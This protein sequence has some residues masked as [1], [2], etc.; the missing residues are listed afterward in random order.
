MAATADSESELE[1]VENL[2]AASEGESDVDVVSYDCMTC[3]KSIKSLEECYPE[4]QRKGGLI[5]HCLKCFSSEVPLGCSPQK[6]DE[7]VTSIEEKYETDKRL[8]LVC[9]LFVRLLNN[10][11]NN[12]GSCLITQDQK[13]RGN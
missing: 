6:A 4:D 10:N 9:L 13:S 7:M 12:N 11:N 8:L 1:D 2:F 5:F 3:G